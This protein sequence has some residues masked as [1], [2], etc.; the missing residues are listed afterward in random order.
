MPDKG[1][2][3]KVKFENANYWDYFNQEWYELYLKEKAKYK[4]LKQA[5]LN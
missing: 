5:K 3:K 2:P 4:E 1:K